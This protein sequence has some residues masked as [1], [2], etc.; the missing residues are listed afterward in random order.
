MVP[1]L[2]IILVQA[3]RGTVVMADAMVDQPIH[4]DVAPQILPHLLTHLRSPNPTIRYPLLSR[5]SYRPFPVIVPVHDDDGPDAGS[6]VRQRPI[7]YPR[8]P[9]Y[10]SPNSTIVFYQAML[11]HPTSNENR[12]P[13]PSTAPA[14]FLASPHQ[15]LGILSQRDCYRSSVVLSF[16][17]DRP[18]RQ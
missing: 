4:L 3:D 8:R 6:L 1:D 18:S 11:D 9:T 13:I 10:R 12:L 5:L 17:F 15:C 14:F 2:G 16:R 7:I